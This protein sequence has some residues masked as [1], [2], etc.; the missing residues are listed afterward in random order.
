MSTLD[1]GDSAD[2]HQTSQRASHS[3]DAC[4]GRDEAYSKALSSSGSGVPQG[5]DGR[6]NDRDTARKA[7][8]ILQ[9]EMHLL[10]M[11]AR[12]GLSRSLRNSP[13]ASSVQSEGQSAASSSHR[14]R[15][16]HPPRE[17]E[18][19]RSLGSQIE[20]V[21]STFIETSIAPRDDS[22]GTVPYFSPRESSSR[23]WTSAGVESSAADS[24]SY[25]TAECTSPRDTSTVAVANVSVAQAPVAHAP[26]VQ[27]PV[28]QTPVVHTSCAY[29]SGATASCA[30]ASCAYASGA[31]KRLQTH[32]LRLYQLPPTLPISP[33]VPASRS[34]DDCDDY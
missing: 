4:E 17:L 12:V 32:Q 22:Q 8:E 5:L 6:K 19:E 2:W 26:V 27:T 3:L 33:L 31:K 24:A 15:R 7:V 10:K 16:R 14:S 20:E 30:N 29:T 9:A 1:D 21:L 18:Q 23:S 11:D 25:A 34:K 28:V 13:E